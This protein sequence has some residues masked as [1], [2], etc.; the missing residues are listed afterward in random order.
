[1]AKRKQEVALELKV[2][3]VKELAPH[4]MTM[5]AYVQSPVT[6]IVGLDNTQVIGS[7]DAKSLYPTIMVLMNI[8]YDTLRGRIYDMN[9]VGSTINMIKQL[10]DLSLTELDTKKA[11]I[12]NYNVAL[13]MAAKKYSNS[14]NLPDKIP[15][16]KFIEFFEKFYSECFRKIIESNITFEQLMTPVNDESYFLLKSALFP[17]LEALTWISPKN[18]GYSNIA[19]DWVFYNNQFKDKYKENDEFLVF[20]E[21]NSTK[22]TAYLLTRD[23]FIDS[24]LTK[25][26]I[27]PYGTY[28]DLHDNN[29]SF[30]VD[31]ILTGMEDRA[32]V[33]NQMLIILAI[34]ENWK[35]IPVELQ[36]SFLQINSGISEDDAEKIVNIVGDSDPKVRKWQKNNLLSIKFNMSNVDKLLVDLDIMASQQNNT[37][38]SIKTSLNS[39][40]GLY[41]MA[42][43]GWG[44]VLISNSITNGGKIYGTKLFQQ[45]A[46]NRLNLE[47]EKIKQLQ[48]KNNDK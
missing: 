3:V 21:I 41:G 42:T 31:T 45:I 4:L 6:Q 14:G 30:E 32:F 47:N 38:N 12:I 20:H 19:I 9:I 35:K 18:K 11:G 10:K 34:I 44:N 39:G 23:I 40:Y 46:V 36:Y 27:N 7:Q 16:S 43:W 33:K 5:G 48:G 8:G 37:S 17:L 15:K 1:M 25:Y 2:S 24:I 22:C 28:F 29:K 13:N 26:I